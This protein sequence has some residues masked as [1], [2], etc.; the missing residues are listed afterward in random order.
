MRCGVNHERCRIDHD[1]NVAR[2]VP[3]ARGE[4]DCSESDNRAR[5]AAMEPPY[6]LAVV[7]DDDPDIAL[8]ARLALRNVFARIETLSSPDD[9]LELVR[10]QE[11]D[12]I[13]LDLNFEGGATGGLEG[14]AFLAKVIEAD[15]QAA[16][17]IITA[18]GA[19][20]VAVEALKRGASDFVAKP[21]ANERLAATVQ[22]AAELRRT[23]MQARQEQARSSE[24]APQGN[25]TLIG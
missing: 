11:P 23:R 20:S 8:A 12:V 19:V 6:A 22:S 21:W 10:R 7:V 17:V 2:T 4:D 3:I 16:V 18:H 1:S 25:V 24:I 15:P 13:L 14:L 9:L 5:L